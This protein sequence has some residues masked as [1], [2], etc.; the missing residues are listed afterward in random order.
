MKPLKDV[1]I[2]IGP[3][4]SGKGSLSYLCKK[5]FGWAHL[6]TGNLCRQHIT[7]KSPLGIQIDQAI[8]AGKLISDDLMIAMVAEWMTEV[9]QT[10]QG[11]I[12]DGFPR[13]VAQ[14]EALA[15]LFSKK[16]ELHA[17]VTIVIMNIND[18]IV[19]KRL[20]TRFVCQKDSC[21]AVY[22][23]ETVGGRQLVSC[24][25]CGGALIQRTDDQSTVA[26][27]RLK[28]YHRHAGDLVGYYR[29]SQEKVI[30]LDVTSPLEQVFESFAR[31]TGKWA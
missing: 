4:G 24:P 23:C 5:R 13:T 19:M 2:F 25:E 17:Q 7:Q 22:S 18:E 10:A 16:E 6:S 31:S 27:E 1:Y 30:D 15:T 28:T 11:V 21:Q 9:M 14:A 8:N 20:K 12:F 29:N 26:H 3:P